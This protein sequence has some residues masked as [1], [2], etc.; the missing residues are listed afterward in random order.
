MSRRRSLCRGL[1]VVGLLAGAAIAA[2]AVQAQE[3]TTL[4][5]ALRTGLSMNPN[6]ESSTAAAA[7][8]TSSRWADWG[9][10]LPT[11]DLRGS[12]SQTAFTNVTFV[13]P[14]GVAQTLDPPVTSERKSSSGSVT[15]GL[16]LLNP[17]RIANVQAGDARENAAD[18]RLTAAERVVIRDVKWSYFE[19]LKQRK[20]LDVSERQLAARRQDFAVT[21]QRYRIAASSRSDLLG[22]EMDLSDAELRVL[23]SVDALSR[24]LRQ[25]QVTLGVPVTNTDPGSIELVDVD[26]VPDAEPL[27]ADALVVTALAMNPNILALQQDQKAATADLWSA[28]GS[29][30]P[31]I[32]LGYSLGRSKELGRD[33]SLL[34]FSPANTSDGFVIQGSWSVFSGFSRKRQTAQADMQRR[35]SA[36][37]LT[38]EQL[39]L[40]KE[41]RDLVK[42]LKR[43][44]QR[45]TI[46]DRNV[47]LASERLS[48][49]REQYRLGSIPYFNL[50][51]AIDRLTLTEQALFQERYDYLIGWASLEEKVGGDLGRGAT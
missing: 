40:E 17:E 7:A 39:Q 11:I 27:D 48:L 22:A 5:E 8:A 12:L 26:L 4:E 47:Q 34:D 3:V 42:E 9:A 29:Y 38:A 46:L 31:R 18:F 24:A 33:E 19:A 23:D 20:L 36:A 32:D 50:Q 51:Q 16:A 1:S 35:Q 41:V 13:D 49:A 14:T 6:I 21:E 45:L 25:L 37:R 10:F 44:S 43:R 28:K 30:L 2:P 15:F